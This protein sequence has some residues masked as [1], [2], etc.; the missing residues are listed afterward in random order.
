MPSRPSSA[1]KAKRVCPWRRSSRCPGET[2]RIKFGVSPG[3]RAEPPPPAEQATTADAA[4]IGSLSLKCKS[5]ERAQ[6]TNASWSRPGSRRHVLCGKRPTARKKDV[7]AR[8]DKSHIVQHKTGRKGKATG[9]LAAGNLAR[10]RC[11]RFIDAQ[12]VLILRAREHRPR[13]R[14]PVRPHSANLEKMGA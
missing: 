12:C 7:F 14:A 8:S 5:H 1:P 11:H 4:K 2:G 10:P 13:R 3:N 9:G 6:I